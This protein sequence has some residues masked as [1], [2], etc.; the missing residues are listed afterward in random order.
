MTGKILTWVVP[1]I[2]A[3]GAAMASPLFEEQANSQHQGLTASDWVAHLRAPDEESRQT[4]AAALAEMGPA[5]RAAVPDLIDAL[6]DDDPEVRWLAM[7]VLGKIGPDA[8]EASKLLA[9][10]IMEAEHVA[11][12]REGVRALR[13]IMLPAGSP[14][15]GGT[16]AGIPTLEPR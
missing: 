8:R 14:K 11:L 9:D 7:Q 3:L 2:G 15:Q 4:A 1:F 12:V 13:S 6:N 5:A 16:V 10:K